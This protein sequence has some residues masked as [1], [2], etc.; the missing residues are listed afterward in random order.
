MG[1]NWVK[2][3]KQLIFDSNTVLN[4]GSPIYFCLYI[5][6][7]SLLAVCT[8]KSAILVCHSLSLCLIEPVKFCLGMLRD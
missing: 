1:V 3:F 7:G 5:S 4:K 6:C 2:W 8:H